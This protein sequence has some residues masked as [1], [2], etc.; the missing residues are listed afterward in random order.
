[1]AL[2]LGGRAVLGPH[3]P[4]YG[5]IILKFSPE[6]FYNN[7]KRVLKQPFKS[8]HFGSNGTYPNFTTLV[9]F[10]CPIYPSKNKN[11]AKKQNFCE[12]P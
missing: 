6:V 7:T 1:M 5:R 8:Y 10:L 2:F 9:H 11:I 3:S 12:N 4:K